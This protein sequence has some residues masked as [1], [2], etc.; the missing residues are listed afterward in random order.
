MVRFSPSPSPSPPPSF[1]LL[2]F[3]FFRS[4]TFCIFVCVYVAGEKGLVLMGI[5]LIVWDELQKLFYVCCSCGTI[6][7]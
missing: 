4:C 1:P 5:R 3:L 2:P 6:F 7:Q